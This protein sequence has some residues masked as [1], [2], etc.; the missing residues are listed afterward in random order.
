MEF[1][2]VVGRG[3]A[4]VNDYQLSPT[5]LIHIVLTFN[6]PACDLTGAVAMTLIT[7]TF[8]S[9]ALLLSAFLATLAINPIVAFAIAGAIGQGLASISGQ[10]RKLVCT[11]K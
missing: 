4:N 7:T 9:I 2:R 10:Y 1:K 11:V 5:P 6:D 3:G 8:L